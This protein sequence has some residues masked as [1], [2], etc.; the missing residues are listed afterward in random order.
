M[1]KILAISLGSALPFCSSSTPGTLKAAARPA[2]MWVTDGPSH[3]PDSGVINQDHLA[4]LPSGILFQ[5][6]PLNHP[7]E[8]YVSLVSAYL[9]SI[10]Y[11]GHTSTGLLNIEVSLLASIQ[12]HILAYPLDLLTFCKSKKIKIHFLTFFIY[13]VESK[14]KFYLDNFK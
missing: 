5:N 10:V 6:L 7:L 4:L 2:S 1:S 9:I 3:T 14:D 11:L 13:K 12:S 8:D